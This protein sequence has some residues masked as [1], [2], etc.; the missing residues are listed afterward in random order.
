MLPRSPSG[1]HGDGWLGR[2]AHH[3]CMAWNAT[4][5]A[6]R[7]IAPP[8]GPSRCVAVTGPHVRTRGC[9]VSRRYCAWQAEGVRLLGGLLPT[10]LTRFPAMV[11]V[12]PA[13]FWTHPP[14][15][16]KRSLHPRASTPC[17]QADLEPPHAGIPGRSTARGSGTSGARAS[18]Q[19]AN[20]A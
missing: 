9:G 7:S 14:H 16:P 4:Q 13:E 5:C 8:C 10:R 15:R 12:H 19:V 1:V 11:G 20:T 3:R 17:F 18:D 2:S 6:L